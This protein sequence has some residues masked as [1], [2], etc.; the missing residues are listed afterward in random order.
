M[1]K[2]V[3]CIPSIFKAGGMERVL[4]IKASWLAEH[5][6]DVTIV[7]TGQQNKA[8][9]YELSSK[10][11]LVDLDINYDDVTGGLVQQIVQRRKK[12]RVHRQRLESF[13][14]TYKADIVISMYTHELPFLHKIQDGSRKILEYHFSRKMEDIKA[15][16]LPF[17]S[18]LIHRLKFLL[19]KRHISKYEKFILL[20]KRDEVDW[21][22]R[23]NSMVIPN[24]ITIKPI[25]NHPDKRKKL[26]L[27]VG[28][29]C[30]QKGFDL[31]LMAW[32]KVYAQ[33]PDWRLL[34]VGTGPDKERLMSLAIRLGIVESVKWETPT[35]TIEEKYTI[36]SIFAMTSR[37][38]GFSL[39]LAEA[40]SCGLP[41]VAFDCPCGP[42]DIVQDDKTG[43][44]IHNGDINAFAA[45]LM[46][47]MASPELRNKYGETAARETQLRFDINSV[48]DNWARLFETG[49]AL[50]RG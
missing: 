22:N 11:S 23:R 7:T 27:A 46:K 35:N 21:G 18:R 43:L 1:M 15:S 49:G 32:E 4:S 47:M 39:V 8:T 37:Y 13:L 30:F 12:L 20:T 33:F 17:P 40:Q 3:Y 6:Y 19:E 36:S 14:K 44:L 24:P 50:P 29:L 42:S 25:L 26:V 34:I 41:A 2:I 45:A 48:M 31:L 5:G 38:E 10:I 16:E 28:R 9:F